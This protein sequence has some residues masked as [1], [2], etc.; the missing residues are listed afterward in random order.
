MFSVWYVQFFQIQL[1]D[2]A[3]AQDVDP[4]ADTI[5][6]RHVIESDEEEDEYN[7]IRTKAASVELNQIADV[8]V[9]GDFPKSHSLLIA[10]GEVGKFWAKGAD[11]GEQCGAIAV[12]GI[13]V[14]VC[15]LPLLLVRRDV[16]AGWPRLPSGMDKSHHHHL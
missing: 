10:V 14:R 1:I 13:Q 3:G 5:P 15:K 4:L 2:R 7:P 16:N 8:K 6:P 9:I 11:L 12:N